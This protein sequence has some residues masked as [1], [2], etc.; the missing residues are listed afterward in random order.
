MSHFFTQSDPLFEQDN[1]SA[2]EALDRAQFIA[3]APYV[4]EASRLLVDKGILKLV[5]EA[6]QAGITI[7]EI[8]RATGLSHYGLKALNNP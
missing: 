6:H 5:D 2:L 3:F 4:W 1:Y 8:V 7:P